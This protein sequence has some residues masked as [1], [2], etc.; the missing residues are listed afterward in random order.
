MEHHSID[1]DHL[2][3]EPFAQV[4]PSGKSVRMNRAFLTLAG[5]FGSDAS[6]PAIF[7]PAVMELLGEADRLGRAS[8]ASSPW[9][10]CRP[11]G[12]APRCWR[13]RRRWA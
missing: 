7:G 6:L 1:L 12:S 8:S 13:V 11:P 3:D 2:L 5:S 9:S 4:M 10:A